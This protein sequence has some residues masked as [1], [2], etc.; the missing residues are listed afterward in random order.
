MRVVEEPST[1]IGK[2]LGKPCSVAERQVLRFDHF[3]AVIV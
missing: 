3:H 1:I 2:P